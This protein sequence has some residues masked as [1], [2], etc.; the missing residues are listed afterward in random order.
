M[1]CLYGDIV[2]TNRDNKDKCKN[3]LLVLIFYTT[4]LRFD[5]IYVV[6]FI[7]AIFTKC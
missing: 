6:N 5:C 2:I 1:N 3:K 4:I 7:V